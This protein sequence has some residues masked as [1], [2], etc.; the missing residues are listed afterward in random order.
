MSCHVIC[1]FTKME[2][3]VIWHFQGGVNLL[4]MARSF[5]TSIST[6]IYLLVVCSMQYPY[7]VKKDG[8]V[9]S[10]TTTTTTL[11]HCAHTGS[12]KHHHARA[13]PADQ[14]RPDQPPA[15]RLSC[16]FCQAQPSSRQARSNGA[17]STQ[18][19]VARTRVALRLR[20]RHCLLWEP[21][22]NN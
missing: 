9:R 4:G 22:K 20:L 19:S 16:Q 10:T 3:I 12:H 14:A 8:D 5:R 2:V 17:L 13:N 1:H 6:S 7:R 21:I 18:H 15:P 11:L